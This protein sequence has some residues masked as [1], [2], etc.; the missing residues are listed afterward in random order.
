MT[1]PEKVLSVAES[2]AYE[3]G[4]FRVD[5]A[6]R[7]LWSSGN[8]V[9]ISAK[10]FDTLLYLVRHAGTTVSKDELMATVWPD[11]VVEENNL[12]KNISV[13]R[14][15][16]GEKP[17]EHRYIATVPGKGYRFVAPVVQIADEATDTEAAVHDARLPETRSSTP[18]AAH[19]G[20]RR[21]SRFWIPSAGIGLAIALLAVVV[22]LRHPL[23]SDSKPIHSIAVLPFTAIAPGS[24]NE[25][26]EFGMADSLVTQLSKSEGLAVRPFSETRRYA[27]TD[28]NPVAIGRTLG[29]DSVLDGSIQLEGDRIRVTARLI[30]SSDGKQLWA[31]NFDEPMRDVFSLQDSMAER[32]AAVLN[33]RLGQQSRKRYTDNVESYQLFILGQYTALK[34]TPEDHF[35]A[36]EYF[37]KA[38]EK[39]PNYALAYAGITAADV[40]YTFA[41]D[42]R[43]AEMMLEAK[44]AA[45]KSVELDEELPEAHAAVGKVAFSY[46]WDWAEA[47]K[48]LLRA[49]DLDPNNSE[50]LLYLAQL[51]SNLGK[52][53]QALELSERA[54]R[55]DPLTI[56]R[57][58]LE[59]Q[60]LYYAGRY[61]DSIN[62]LQQTID[63]NPNHWLPWMF[64]ARP[65]IE[66]GMFRDAIASC[67]RAKL[68]GGSPSLELIALEGWSYAKLG[69]KD[70]ARAALKQLEQISANRYVPSYFPALIHNALGET[71]AA[72]SLLEKGLAARDVR[73]TFLKVD[74]KWNNLHNEPRF[75]ALLEAMH[76]Q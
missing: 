59:G 1:F 68:L 75:T 76:F 4:P 21:R 27:N 2:G 34:L 26:M 73:M 39:D 10:A 63:M 35:K 44:L 70:K 12:N 71:D 20:L 23:S 55:P 19:D 11:T 41:N 65:Y 7:L 29:V 8:P 13:L 43:P 54:R 58:A 33:A 52:H 22:Y 56:N 17:G 51:Y 3:F 46:D 5:A 48:H 38:I 50:G 40:S 61:D 60:F 36:V 9:A 53:Q 6:K 66:K 69:D 31:S 30:R 72:L 47:E 24:R 45:M 74:P 15:V 14:Q 49:Y 28:R 32:T 64:I 16:L 37:R 67:E 25:A 18:V 62:V 57:P 42:A